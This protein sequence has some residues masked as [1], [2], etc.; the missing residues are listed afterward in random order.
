MKDKKG[1]VK[2]IKITYHKWI[3]VNK[4]IYMCA[5]IIKCM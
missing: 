4:T 5:Y 3:L 1:Y 2:K